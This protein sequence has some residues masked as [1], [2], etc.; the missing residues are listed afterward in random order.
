MATAEQ[1]KAARVILES[2][3]DHEGQ[4]GSCGWHG[5]LYEHRVDD[6]DIADAI[7]K[8]AGILTLHCVSEDAMYS[9]DH[10]GVRISLYPESS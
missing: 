4:C 9:L 2:K 8:E 3:W 1:I 7:D 5:L 6:D 10:R